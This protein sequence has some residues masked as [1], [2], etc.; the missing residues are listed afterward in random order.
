MKTKHPEIKDSL[1]LEFHLNFGRMNLKSS[2]EKTL[3]N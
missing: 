3:N 1:K 2:L